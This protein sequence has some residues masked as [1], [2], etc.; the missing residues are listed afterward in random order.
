VEFS[1][2]RESDFSDGTLD[3]IT[4]AISTDLTQKYITEIK[5]IIIT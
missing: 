5:A 3:G 4:D 1:Q 2:V